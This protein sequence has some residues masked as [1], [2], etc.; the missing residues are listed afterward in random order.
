LPRV[1]R[2]R[3]VRGVWAL[4]S[5]ATWWMRNCCS[6]FG[7]RRLHVREAVERPLDHD[8]EGRTEEGRD[9][10]RAPRGAPVTPRDGTERG[11]RHGGAVVPEEPH[12][13][14]RRPE[15]CAVSGRQHPARPRPQQEPGRPQEREAE[16]R[17]LPHRDDVHP[18]HGRERE[19]G[20]HGPRRPR[21]CSEAPRSCEEVTDQQN[22]DQH[23]AKAHGTE[24]PPRAREQPEGPGVERGVP[25]VVPTVQDL[26][27]L[28]ERIVGDDPREEGQ[29]VDAP[30]RE[31]RCGVARPGPS[32]RAMRTPSR[33]SHQR[34]GTYTGT[35]RYRSGSSRPL[36]AQ[37]HAVERRPARHHAA[38]PLRRLFVWAAGRVDPHFPTGLHN[39]PD[40]SVPLIWEIAVGLP[41]PGKGA[42][43]R[44][45]G[46]RTL[47]TCWPGSGSKARRRL[48]AG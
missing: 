2:S 24:R 48:L 4:R 26:L 36:P 37:G 1:F 41:T 44:P 3:D 29:P 21:R 25:V 6:S 33:R 30:R 16:R 10:D 38:E 39:R 9:Q 23:L 22:G 42:C 40:V 20:S 31:R 12:Q 32:R 5:P 43:C 17:V 34:S 15:P 28:D 27:P 18:E 45:T 13:R 35:R 8:D 11:Q 7:G 19:P 46:Y 47:A 14:E